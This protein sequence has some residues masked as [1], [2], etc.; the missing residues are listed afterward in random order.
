MASLDDYVAAM[1]ATQQVAMIDAVVTAVT[2]DGVNLSA[3]GFLVDGVACLAG[4]TGR[5]VDDVV[6][7]LTFAKRW[8]VLGRIGP[9]DTSTTA[10]QIL[11]GTA[12]PA[13]SGWW[14][15]ADSGVWAKGST[16]YVEGVANDGSP[17]VSAP[18]TSPVTIQPSQTGAWRE[19][20]REAGS[21]PIQG[22][23]PTYPHP[24][25]GGWFYGTDIASACAGKTVANMQFRAVRQGKS[26][27]GVYG[28]AAMRLFLHNYTTRPGGKPALSNQW[29][30][31]N[32]QPSEAD[33]LSMPSSWITAL[34]AGS[35]RGVGCDAG[36]AE[37]TYLKY[38]A[39][40]G[41]IRITFQ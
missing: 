31:G 13:G 5:A 4:Y 11:W 36:T 30:A 3:S 6:L 33:W 8:V 12:A 17:P 10:A 20:D 9:E 24:Y 25:T 27:G 1:A 14:R 39:S 16:I 37:S 40:S 26:S 34:A 18:S 15:T 19:G 35:K 29:N 7:V 32:L 38:T 41:A 28:G 21:P 23:W 2:D 22:A